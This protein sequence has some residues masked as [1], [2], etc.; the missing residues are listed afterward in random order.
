MRVR[1]DPTVLLSSLG[2]GFLLVTTGCAMPSADPLANAYF[3]VDDP[4]EEDL[5]VANE[6][7]ED[8]VMEF[9]EQSSR[10]ILDDAVA[11]VEED[12][13]PIL[14][15]DA[16]DDSDVMPDGE[17]PGE[18]PSAPKPKDEPFVTDAE[19]AKA[20]GQIS[21]K[22]IT[23]Y[24]GAYLW[25][26]RRGTLSAKD[27][28]FRGLIDALMRLEQERRVRI[29]RRK[30]K[31]Y[32]RG[33]FRG[34]S[35]FQLNRDLAGINAVLKRT[36]GRVGPLSEGEKTWTTIG[37]L[38]AWKIHGE[39]YERDAPYAYPIHTLSIRTRQKLKEPPPQNFIWPTNG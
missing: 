2:M 37:I 9:D 15:D 18:G 36:D 31:A 16:M 35:V 33:E 22:N 30:P 39:L 10:E 11:Q 32:H 38:Q 7:L 14:P 23:K 19:L 5:E 20:Y 34:K 27:K 1:L 28:E 29:G 13:G 3:D 21:N 25:D 26:L 4:N 24:R 12:D 8:A 6:V 17:G